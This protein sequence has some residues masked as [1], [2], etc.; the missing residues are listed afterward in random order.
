[1]GSGKSGVSGGG[2]S[3]AGGGVVVGN[4]TLTQAMLNDRADAYAKQM[5]R[6]QTLLSFKVYFLVSR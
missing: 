4:S 3:P 1:M 6:Y 2:K 5:S